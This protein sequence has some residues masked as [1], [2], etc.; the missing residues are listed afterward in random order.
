MNLGRRLAIL[1]R[2]VKLLDLLLERLRTRR[3]NRRRKRLRNRRRL[4]H[5]QEDRNYGCAQR[6]QADQ[7]IQL[8]VEEFH[9]TTPPRTFMLQARKSQSHV[10]KVLRKVIEGGAAELA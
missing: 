3:R 5:Y 10:T 7:A 6:R 9:G 8:H 2:R 4:L 1:R